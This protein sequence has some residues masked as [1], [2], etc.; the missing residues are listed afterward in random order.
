MDYRP[1]ISTFWAVILLLRA[2]IAIRA[3]A[4]RR[5]TEL[6]TTPTISRV[7][8]EEEGEEEGKGEGEG[9]PEVDGVTAEEREVIQMHVHALQKQEKGIHAS[10]Q[11]REYGVT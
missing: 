10:A 7:G 2:S 5:R 9:I 4:M 6:T 3:R 1:F 11:Q 8:E